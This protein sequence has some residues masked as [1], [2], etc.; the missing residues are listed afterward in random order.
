MRLDGEHSEETSIRREV[1]EGCVLSPDLCNLYSEN[2]L[3][4]IEDVK[5]IGSSG[6]NF[7]NLRYTDDTVL[8]AQSEETLQHILDTV[9]EAHE[10]K[11]LNISKQKA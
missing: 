9:M 6:H 10:S 11:G 3:R 5:G 1:R 4:E 7:S 8:T 2:I